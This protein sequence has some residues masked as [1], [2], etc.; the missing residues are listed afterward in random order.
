MTNLTLYQS[1]F[2]F[3]LQLCKLFPALSPFSIRR[4]RAREVFLLMRRLNETTR[5]KKVKRP[6]NDNW[7]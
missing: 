7:F 5:P 6:A 2:D 1:Y 3:E 4:E